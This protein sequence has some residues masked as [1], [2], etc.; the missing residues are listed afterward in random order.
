MDLS[1]FIGYFTKPHGFKGHLILK[2]ENDFDLD[3]ATAL[4]V[5]T[6]TGKAPYF[7]NEIKDANNGVIIGLEEVDSA[8]KAK[9]LI[10]K[11]IYVETKHL[12]KEEEGVEWLDYEVVD[13]ELG[14]LGKVEGV[15]D[16]GQQILLSLTYKQREIIL[17][18]VEAFIEK[19][20][21]EKKILYF[22]AP[23]GLIDVYLGDSTKP[24]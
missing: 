21:E 23:E 3:A 19:V 13:A 16:N 8:E 17:P 22:R 9:P 15:S 2:I 1:S 24:D 18:L 12:I 4:F 10:G 20:D 5:E 6:A 14:S 7:V 11:K